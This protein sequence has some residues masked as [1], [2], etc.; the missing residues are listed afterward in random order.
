[1]A[2]AQQAYNAAEQRFIARNPKSKAIYE[3]ATESLPGGNTRSVLFYEP[4]PLSI[5]SANGATLHSA[6]GH[7]YTDLLGEYTAGV[8]GH[9]D[10]VIAQAIIETTKKGL[11]F[12]SHHEDEGRLAGLIKQRF[13]SIELMRF[14]NSGTEANLM[15]LAAAKIATGKKKI[16]VFANGYHGGT[17]LFAGGKSSS[18]NVPHEYLIATYNDLESVYELIRKPENKEN[19]AAIIV[20]PMMGSGGCIPA[21]RRFLEGLRKAADESKAVLIYDEVMTSRSHSGGGIQ[22][23]LP[24]EL[25]PDLTSLGKYIGGGMS[26]GAFGGKRSIMD[27]FDPRHPDSIKH[28]G[29]FNNNVLTMAAGRVGLEQVFTPYRAQQLHA[30]GDKLRQRLQDIGRGT[31]MKVTGVG[32]IMGIHFTRTVLEDIKSHKDIVDS[33]ATLSNLLHLF[34]LDRGFY[35]ARRG[36]IALS[37]AL[38]ES[39]LDGFAKTVQDFVTE[40]RQILG[41]DS[42]AKL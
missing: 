42:S 34:L 19:V 10:P 24:M 13:P 1:M 14:T 33:D 23:Q 9:S 32:S 35:I 3:K 25:R 37:L 18:I 39:D 30:T 5:T 31:L 41:V 8:Y 16:V 26:F 7:A 22:S 28:A 2:T 29:T 27:I 38:T 36:F 21:D 17:F 15:A 20:E 12:G 6:D 11:N 40:H 4:F